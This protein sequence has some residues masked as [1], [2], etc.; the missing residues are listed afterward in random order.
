MCRVCEAQTGDILLYYAKRQGSGRSQMR[1]PTG[2]ESAASTPLGEL[3]AFVA[4]L[5]MQGGATVLDA[6]NRFNAFRVAHTVRLFTSDISVLSNIKTARAF[7]SYQFLTLCRTTKTSKHP[8]LV[9]DLLD[10]FADE[11]IKL[12]ERMRLLQ[13]CLKH[14]K[15][16]SRTASLVI[17]LYQPRHIFEGYQQMLAQ[18]KRIS[19]T[20]NGSPPLIEEGFMGKTLPTISDVIRE[21]EIILK[22]FWRVLQPEER[23][24]LKT[25]F[26]EAKRHV[27]AISE[28]NHLLP[29]ETV[30]QA[31]LLEQAKQIQLLRAEVDRLRRRIDG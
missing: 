21:S 1:I 7:T 12:A 3:L 28:A 20:G 4:H 27:A 31:M 9:L 2:A 13:G 16:L 10:T 26:A 11:G 8:Y 17:S 30:Q 29:F 19:H 14:L 18:V 24:L 15:R 23:E 6:G 5:G 25:M 22:R